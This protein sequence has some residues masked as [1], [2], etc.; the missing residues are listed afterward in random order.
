MTTVQTANNVRAQ[1]GYVYVWGRIDYNDGF[2]SR[3]R[4][5]CHRYNCI[6]LDKPQLH[7]HHNDGD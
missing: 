6:S 2:T 7:H 1:R 5:F 3:W 4:T